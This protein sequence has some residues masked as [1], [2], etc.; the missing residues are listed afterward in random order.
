MDKE[1]ILAKSRQENKNRDMED[2][3]VQTWAISIATKVGL[4]ICCLLS[5]LEVIF[6]DSVS[7]ASW[8][9]FFGILGTTMVLKFVK[10]R[11]KHELAVGLLYL[12]LCAF[13]FALHLRDLLGG[14]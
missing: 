3:Q 14:A 6:R 1:E 10:L 12:A 4:M 11:R 2:L 9:I 13:F 8:T 7:T 5:V